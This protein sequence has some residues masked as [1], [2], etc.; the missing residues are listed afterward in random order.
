LVLPNE[1]EIASLDIRVLNSH[2][3]K[4]SVSPILSIT[5]ILPF[6][7]CVFPSDRAAICELVAGGGKKTQNFLDDPHYP[8]PMLVYTT[9]QS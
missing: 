5:I 4:S 7:N 3:H 6:H 9:F 8:R 1:K 2:C